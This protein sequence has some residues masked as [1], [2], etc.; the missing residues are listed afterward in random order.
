MNDCHWYLE[1]ETE[2]S[3]SVDFPLVK[4]RIIIMLMENWFVDV[5]LFKIHF[6]RGIVESFLRYYFVDIFCGNKLYFDALDN[7]KYSFVF[8][9]KVN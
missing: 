3:G 2:L 7:A 6:H 8:R 5:C 9:V 1:C 4:R